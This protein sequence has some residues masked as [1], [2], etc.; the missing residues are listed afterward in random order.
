MMTLARDPQLQESRKRERADAIRN[1]IIADPDKPRTLAEAI[2]PNGTC[3]DMCAEYERV[4]RVVQKDVWSEET[5]RI[6]SKAWDV[7]WVQV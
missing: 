7:L 3:Q 5:V 4:E 2:T 6:S 1:G